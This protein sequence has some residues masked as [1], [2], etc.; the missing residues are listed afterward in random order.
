MYRV[1]Q[2]GDNTN[3]TGWRRLEIEYRVEQ[4]RESLPWVTREDS[5]Q[6]DTD[7]R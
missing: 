4:N 1:T 2:A 5:V 7:W 3:Y 6:G